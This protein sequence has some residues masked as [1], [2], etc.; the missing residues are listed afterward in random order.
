MPARLCLSCDAALD[1]C[2]GTLIVHSDRSVECT[3]PDC[4]D[5]D[6]TRH[7][8]VVDCFDLAGGC[9][10]SVTEPTRDPRSLA[11]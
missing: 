11:G 7:A 8:F 9:R 3:E 6:H 5:H 1:H 2:H 10:C 4:S